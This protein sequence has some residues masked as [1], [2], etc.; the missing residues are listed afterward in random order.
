MTRK[1]V[2]PVL[3]LNRTVYEKEITVAKDAIHV[4][5]SRL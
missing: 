5:E 1:G 4:I 3:E 2:H